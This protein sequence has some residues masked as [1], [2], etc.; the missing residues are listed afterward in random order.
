MGIIN[1]DCINIMTFMGIELNKEYYH[2]A[3]DR[4][5]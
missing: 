1:G 4:L 3:K 5:C 2:I